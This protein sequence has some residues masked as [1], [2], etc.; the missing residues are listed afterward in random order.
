MLTDADFEKARQPIRSR[1]D[2][3]TNA[4][5]GRGTGYTVANANTAQDWE[6]RWLAADQERLHQLDLL[7]S[8]IRDPSWTRQVEER[9]RTSREAADARSQAGYREARGATEAG[10]DKAG[11]AG[12][13]IDAQRQANLT[14]KLERAKAQASQQAEEIRQAGL[15]S[16][17]NVEKQL[18][19]SILA[20]DE[21]YQAALA[22]QQ[23]GIQAAGMQAG[24]QEDYNALLSNAIAG[25]LNNTGQP[26]ITE[27]FTAAD[28]A[29]QANYD[30]W[31][32]HGYQG[33]RPARANW[34]NL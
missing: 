3:L 14:V 8:A 6:G 32:D 15:I 2:Y 17:G 13:S 20:E 22:A 11:M 30:Q 29:D 25:V 4:I 21:D 24:V 19:D 10:M 26:L 16:L 5:T 34:W 18:M 31:A 7:Q 33:E 28:R 12:S 27:G 1:T 23:T 9:A